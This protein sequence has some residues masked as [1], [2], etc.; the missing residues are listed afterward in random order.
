MLHM[1]FE[2]AAEVINPVMWEIT[3]EHGPAGGSVSG[4]R[5]ACVGG[6]D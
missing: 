6:W 5:S 3:I 2:C 1:A 4:S